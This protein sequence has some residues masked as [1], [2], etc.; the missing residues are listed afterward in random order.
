ME[1]EL[2]YSQIYYR[3]NRD[4]LRAKSKA[5]YEA[6][7]KEINRKDYERRSSSPEIRAKRAEKQREYRKNNRKH[8]ADRD[9]A[10][11][12][13]IPIEEVQELR[14]IPNCEICGAELRHYAKNGSAIDH[15]HTTGKVRG[16]L[17][18]HCN[19]ALGLFFDNT[20]TLQQAILYLEERS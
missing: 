18:G 6:N 17:C 19:K 1:E 15:C 3:R 4:H 16:M 11:T 5:F 8:C 12:F 10:R 20:A 14:S 2:T 13:G 7:K 9:A